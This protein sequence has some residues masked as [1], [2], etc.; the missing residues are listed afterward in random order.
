MSLCIGILLEKEIIL[1]VSLNKL[2]EISLGVQITIPTGKVDLF[3][4]LK[5]LI[6][7]RFLN[8]GTIVIKN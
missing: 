7:Y 6:T 2:Q 4:D 1:F 3:I 5:L 8:I